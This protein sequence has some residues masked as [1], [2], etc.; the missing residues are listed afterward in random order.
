LLF[1][2]VLT[3]SRRVY[4]PIIAAAARTGGRPPLGRDAAGAA[5]FGIFR[6]IEAPAA[7]TVLA[8]V[9]GRN[10]HAT[11]STNRQIWL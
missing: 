9:P 1:V 2:Y 4:A 7:I 10:N 8:A 6:G 11:E 5:V 3:G